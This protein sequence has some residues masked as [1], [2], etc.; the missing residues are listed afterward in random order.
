MWKKQ[1]AGDA[2]KESEEGD[3]VGGKERAREGMQEED[4]VGG[5]ECLCVLQ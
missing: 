3:K 1:H 2:D 5:V 4:R